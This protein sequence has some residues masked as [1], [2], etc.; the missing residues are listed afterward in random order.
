MKRTT[1]FCGAGWFA[2]LAL[3]AVLLVGCGQSGL[4]VVPVT[5]SVQ[6]EGQPVAEAFITFYPA[7]SEG[8]M[9]SGQT[10]ANGE[11]ALVTA[12]A[13][14]AGVMPGS[15]RV[16]VEK[17]VFVD[18]RGNPI[19]MGSEASEAL[20]QMPKSKSLIPE[21]YDTADTSGLTADVAKKGKNHFVFEL[22][23]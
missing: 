13:A 5:G 4:P 20:Q 15:Y 23:E 18:D 11:F 21:K 6:F 7:G 19:I 14:K 3:F 22:T 12:G 2:I 1:F 17:T 16:S 9:A 10:N 8:R